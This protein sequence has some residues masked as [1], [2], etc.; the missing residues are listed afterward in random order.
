L[1]SSIRFRLGVRV[2]V[3]VRVRDMLSFHDDAVAYT[4]YFVCH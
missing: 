2:R 4:E 1:R 3:R